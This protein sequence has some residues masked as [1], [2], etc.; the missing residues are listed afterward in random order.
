[1]CKPA[2]G[3]YSFLTCAYR[4]RREGRQLAYTRV[5]FTNDAGELVAY[6]REFSSYSSSSSSNIFD[7]RPHKVH[8]EILL[9]SGEFI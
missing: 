8:W 2:A 6:G 7:C 1:M 4:N 5:D 3:K 9:A